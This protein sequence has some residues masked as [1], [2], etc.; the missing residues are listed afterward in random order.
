MITRLDAYQYVWY[1]LFES[2]QLYFKFVDLFV[3]FQKHISNWVS[4][5]SKVL[6]LLCLWYELG[7]KS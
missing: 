6:F 3:C 1:I 5:M 2:L 4:A 7:L